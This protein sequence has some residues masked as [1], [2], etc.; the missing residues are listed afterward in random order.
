M[1][2]IDKVKNIRR[3]TK[4]RHASL[5]KFIDLVK[6]E[7]T[8]TSEYEGASLSSSTPE[9]L[10][11]PHW[12]LY[13]PIFRISSREIMSFLLYISSSNSDCSGPTSQFCL[14]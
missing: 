13:S 8:S 12:L 5:Q 3:F 9:S 4:T 1:K 7:E 11:T 10:S 14:Q 6:I 2:K